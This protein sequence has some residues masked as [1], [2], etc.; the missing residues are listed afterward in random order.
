MVGIKD[1]IIIV[2]YFDLIAK[3]FPSTPTA[4]QCLSILSAVDPVVQSRLN[5]T[6]RLA[7]SMIDSALS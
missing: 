4:S 5:L 6:V 3:C 2:I 7:G 1:I